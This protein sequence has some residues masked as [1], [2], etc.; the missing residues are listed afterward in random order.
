MSGPFYFS[1]MDIGVGHW[2][3]A[4]GFIAAFLV[5][6]VFAYRDDIRKTP[7]LFKGASVILLVVVF[8]LMLMIVV[9]ILTR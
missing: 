4:G 9:K 3:F 7:E 8:S 5:L 1:Q 2:L 6:M